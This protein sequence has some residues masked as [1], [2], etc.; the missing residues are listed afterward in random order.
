V[1]T[2]TAD[3]VGL[4]KRVP[5]LDSFDTPALTLPGVELL[6]ATWELGGVAP[7]APLP[8]ALHPTLPVLAVLA[9]WCADAGPLGRFRVAELRLSC[10]SGA[11]PRQYLA[12]CFVDGDAARAA[13][14]DQFAFGAAPARIALDRFYDRVEASVESR[15]ARVLEL[16]ALAPLPL[17]TSDLQLFS[18]VHP[19][20]TPKGLRLVQIDTEFAFARA[21]RAQPRLAQ[22]D[23]AAF[24][25]PGARLAYPVAAFVAVGDL[26]LP[27]IR[28]VS[29]ADVP[30]HA[31]TER[32]A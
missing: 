28:F 13:L 21:E 8:P 5:R 6:Q 14:N 10:R 12:G 9:L 27:R 25:V 24:G 19:A 30:A 26:T 15:G 3:V 18:S 29:R 11:R 4:A 17:A 31:G 20:E 32:V 22:F 2:G 23:A 7:E 16:A 1:L